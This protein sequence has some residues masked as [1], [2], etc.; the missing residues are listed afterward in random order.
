MSECPDYFTK[1]GNIKED[2]NIHDKNI[3]C[4]IRLG[5]VYKYSPPCAGCMYH[6]KCHGNATDKTEK[7]ARERYPKVYSGEI[8]TRKE[9]L[10]YVRDGVG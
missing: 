8:Q 2:I 7:D 10:K 1:D 3:S 4:M 6:G 5:Y 9:Y